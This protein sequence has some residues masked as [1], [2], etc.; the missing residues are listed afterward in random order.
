[1]KRL[2]KLVNI[3]LLSVSP[4]AWAKCE[5]TQ[6]PPAVLTNQEVMLLEQFPSWKEQLKNVQLQR[7]KVGRSI[8]ENALAA[9]ENS[10][11]RDL[12]KNDISQAEKKFRPA[13]EERFDPRW[14]IVLYVAIKHE[15]SDFV[16]DAL[17]LN[18]R[19]IER[20]RS[21]TRR[22]HP[23]NG[24]PVVGQLGPKAKDLRWVSSRMDDPDIPRSKRKL[25]E[26]LNKITK[27]LNLYAL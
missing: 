20:Y 2:L 7:F 25:E 5:L 27:M 4:L 12:C 3:L 1:M 15:L 26:K 23:S 17:A 18:N 19:S 9:S 10:D 22:Y 11:G 21:E 16:F 8:I 24:Y 6:L 13:T 14:V